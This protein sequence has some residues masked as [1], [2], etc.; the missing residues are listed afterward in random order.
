LS[1]EKI[2]G[3]LVGKTEKSNQLQL[4]EF[5]WK[6]GCLNNGEIPTKS[7][8]SQARAKFKHTA[9]IELRSCLKIIGLIVKILSFHPLTPL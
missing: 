3:L 2:F 8:F 1:F 4:N 6:M 7:A 5:W 9:F